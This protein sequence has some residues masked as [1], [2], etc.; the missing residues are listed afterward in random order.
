MRLSVL[1]SVETFE[2]GG[3]QAVVSRTVAN[4]LQIRRVRQRRGLLANGDI[5]HHFR[6]HVV[7]PDDDWNAVVAV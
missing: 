1:D 6:R 2:I 5:S 3:R 4:V 7:D